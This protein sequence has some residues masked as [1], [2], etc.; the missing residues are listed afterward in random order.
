MTPILQTENLTV[1]QLNPGD[2]DFI[3]ELLNTPGWLKYIGDRN[4]RTTEEAIAYLNNGPI[5]SYRENGFGLYHIAITE[6]NIP[7]GMCGIIKRPTL[8]DPDIGYALL[9]AYAGKGY[10]YEMANAVLQYA[11]NDLKL[12][13]LCAITLP[14][15]TSSVKLLGK[16]GF[17]DQGSYITPDTKETLLLFRY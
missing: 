5:K 8:A 10:A 4:V 14:I 16:L 9:P 2:V 7:I 17:R 12:P 1:R 13:A 11:V 3:V 6:S 15:N